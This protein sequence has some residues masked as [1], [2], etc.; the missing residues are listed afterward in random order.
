VQPAAR[1]AIQCLK[2]FFLN[3]FE[4]GDLEAKRPKVRLP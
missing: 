3:A 1:A 2:L 4:S